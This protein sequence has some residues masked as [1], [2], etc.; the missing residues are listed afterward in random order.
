[1]EA[2]RS[3][4]GGD[5]SEKTEQDS[6]NSARKYEDYRKRRI[7]ENMQ[8]MHEM[9]ITSISISTPARKPSRRTPTKASSLSPGSQG[10]LPSRRSSRLRKISPVNYSEQPNEKKSMGE[11]V[12]TDEGLVPEVYTEEHEKLLG[13]CQNAWVLFQ[14][15]Y[16]RDGKRIYDSLNGKTCHQCR[17]KTLGYRTSCSKCNLVQG[18]FCGDCLYMRYGENVLEAN[19]TPGW[20]CPVCRGICNC[21]LCRIK[22]GWLPTGTLYKKITRLGYKSVA[23]YLIQT[24]RFDAKTEG[25][26]EKV[27][28]STSV[29]HLNFS[30]ADQADIENKLSKQQREAFMTAIPDVDH[31]NE[32]K[33]LSDLT[34]S[35][36]EG[37]PHQNAIVES[38]QGDR[39]IGS[40]ADCNLNSHP[41]GY[42]KEGKAN[43]S[44][45]F[46]P[47]T[48]ETENFSKPKRF[49]ASFIYVR[50]PLMKIMTPTL[51]RSPIKEL[52][53]ER[54]E[55]IRSI[56]GVGNKH[57]SGGT[58]LI[59]DSI[60]GRI[61]RRRVGSE[62]KYPS[63]L[64]SLDD[65]DP[66]QNAINE[67]LQRD[68]EIGRVAADCDLNSSPNG[69]T[70]EGKVNASDGFGTTTPE[71]FSKPKNRNK[72]YSE[73]TTM[74]SDSIVGRIKRR[75]VGMIQFCRA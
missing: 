53:S 72:N 54:R 71:N 32:K 51:D 58:T 65:S 14:D 3:A 73:R 20:I 22:K 34:S 24:H 59:L 50:S 52:D 55:T 6:N 29:R 68:R 19:R 43:A 15:G 57:S 26:H 62:K 2:V 75:H 64:T 66:Q 40:A 23:H 74:I 7:Q 9:G 16:G 49:S 46:S 47:T 10:S 1:M 5:A 37:G 42:T 27:N 36:D 39:E 41:K 4:T 69:Y 18:Q 30:D 61:K 11:K 21:S 28:E 13:S 12:L 48:P 38:L 8:K 67:S 60:A 17:Q 63:Y 44:D 35:L 70:K 56:S 33:Y 25:N 45:A 31:G